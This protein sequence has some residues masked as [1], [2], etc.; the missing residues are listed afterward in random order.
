MVQG[1]RLHWLGGADSIYLKSVNL[2]AGHHG[3]S[4]NK[5]RSCRMVHDS[6]GDLDH[7]H[8]LEG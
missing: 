8:V 6:R 7:L 4:L 5:T 1:Y 2:R 3:L